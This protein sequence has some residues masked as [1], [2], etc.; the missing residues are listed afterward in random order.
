MISETPA[1]LTVHKRACP[2]LRTGQRAS[3]R[4][5]PQPD[6]WLA[7]LFNLAIDVIDRLP[8]LQAT[9]AHTKEWLKDQ[10]VNGVNYAHESG[11][12]RQQIRGWKWP[13]KPSP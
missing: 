12:D 4:H 11:I 6:F 10:I 8:K 3:I 1:R 7:S 5:F 13:T 2:T 9:A